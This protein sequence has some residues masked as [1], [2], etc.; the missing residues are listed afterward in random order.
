MLDPVLYISFR[1]QTDDE[2]IDET[3]AFAYDEESDTLSVDGAHWLRDMRSLPPSPI[4]ALELDLAGLVVSQSSVTAD[5]ALD[6]ALDKLEPLERRRRR[7]PPEPPCLEA[8]RD[9]VEE[10]TTVSF[11]YVKSGAMSRTDREIEPYKVFRKFGSWY[12]YGQDLGRRA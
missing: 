12:V 7:P 4:S 6:A 8:V 11:G 5:A 1:A 10:E 2:M 3:Y 9:G